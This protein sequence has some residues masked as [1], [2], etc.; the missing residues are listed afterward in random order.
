MYSESKRAGAEQRGNRILLLLLCWIILLRRF[1]ASAGSAVTQKRFD[2]AAGDVR[3]VE[4]Q[5]PSAAS[6]QMIKKKKTGI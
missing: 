2:V 4:G 5:E 3:R 1:E 6:R